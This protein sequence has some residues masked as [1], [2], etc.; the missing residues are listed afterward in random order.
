MVIDKQFTSGHLFCGGGGDTDGIIRAGGKP[1]WGIEFSHT[2][3]AVYRQRFPPIEL[4]E[5]DVK[6]LSDTFIRS[7]PIPNI[8][9]AGTPCPDEKHRHFDRALKPIN[10]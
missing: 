7:L 2:A 4:I 8:I 6:T 1:I 5:A 10:F 3:A 9:C